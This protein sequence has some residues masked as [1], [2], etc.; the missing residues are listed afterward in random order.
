MKHFYD[1]FPTLEPNYSDHS[2]YTWYST[3]GEPVDAKKFKSGLT[4]VAKIKTCK[5]PKHSP[6]NG[7]VYESGVYV[8]KCE[9]C[10]DAFE[11]VVPEITY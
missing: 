11:F 10:G 5:S 8:W 6:P 3:T 4:Q 7:M 2:T 9:D 1:F